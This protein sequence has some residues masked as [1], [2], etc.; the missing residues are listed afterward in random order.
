VAGQPGHQSGLGPGIGAGGLQKVG[1]SHREDLT[2]QNDHLDIA[3]GQSWSWA[4]PGPAAQIGAP[5]QC[6]EEPFSGFWP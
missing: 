2:G 6:D 3:H 4:S 1:R 5:R